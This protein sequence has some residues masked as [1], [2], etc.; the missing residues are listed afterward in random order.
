MN[1]IK[2]LTN[3]LLKTSN[4]NPIFNL[5]IGRYNLH[6]NEPADIGSFTELTRTLKSSISSLNQLVHTAY[7]IG[8]A[9]TDPQ[10]L[11]G[12]LAAIEGSLISTA[13]DMAKRIFNC[14]EGQVIGAL[15]RVTGAIANVIN[16][17]LDFLT[18]VDNLLKQIDDILSKLAEDGKTTFYK[19][20]AQEDCE[21]FLAAVGQCL[22]NK[23][24]GSK[25]EKFEEKVTGKIN[26]IGGNI[27][28]AI[29]D[30]LAN[31]KNLTNFLNKETFMV[32]K[33]S[34]QLAMFA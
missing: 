9:I 26:K 27:N 29:T 10:M 17:V 20:S 25:L 7:C 5:N 12:V 4:D 24:I 1:A 34:E 13:V 6:T 18:A 28:Q 11:I 19:F 33:A 14:I 15:R 21:F 32:N 30:E 8:Q 31:T 2:N 23:L 3:N 22:L 16:S